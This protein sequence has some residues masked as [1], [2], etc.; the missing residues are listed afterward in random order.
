MADDICRRYPPDR[1]INQTDAGTVHLPPSLNIAKI[2][3][4]EAMDAALIYERFGRQ[5]G[6]L[7]AQL[8][9]GASIADIIIHKITEYGVV[10]SALHIPDLN[11]SV[12]VMLGDQRAEAI[13]SSR[14]ANHGA[15]LFVRPFTRH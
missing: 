8:Q 12:T 7:A 9:W 1:H 6:S 4:E 3:L 15:M 5:Q 11:A 14:N 13:I 10:F 2:A